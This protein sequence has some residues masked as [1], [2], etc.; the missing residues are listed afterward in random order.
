[1]AKLKSFFN[2]AIGSIKTSGSISPSSKY[3]IN[4]CIKDIDFDKSDILIEFGAGDGCFTEEL[5]KHLNP[6]AKLYVFEIND[7]FYDFCK[8]KF[9][10]NQKVSILKASALEFERFVPDID[11]KK[12]DCIISSLPLSLFSTKDTEVLLKKAFQ[13]LKVNGS[14]IQYQY[15]FNLKVYKLLKKYFQNINLDFTF[16]NVPPAI[17]YKCGKN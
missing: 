13:Q 15:T 11:I 8:T 2:E 17:I 6:K 4:D 5:I 14:Y 7:V 12:V 9:A 10:E 3:L 16:R 1:M